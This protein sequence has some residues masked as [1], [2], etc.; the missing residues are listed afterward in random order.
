MTRIIVTPD[1]E[2][3]GNARSKGDGANE[4]VELLRV[5]GNLWGREYAPGVR[6]KCGTA[7]ISVWVACVMA[8]KAPDSYR[9]QPAYEVD[10]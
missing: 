6:K 4:V 8:C 10:A 3:I 5:C 9:M 1:A 7:H 2:G